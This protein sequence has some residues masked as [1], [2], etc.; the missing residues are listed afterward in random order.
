VRRGGAACHLL[1]GEPTAINAGTAAYFIG[2]LVIG[3]TELDPE[4]RL[5]I[6]DL[7]FETLRATH[8]GQAL[9]IDGLQDVMAQ[10]V[11]SGNGEALEQHILGT[12]RLKSAVPARAL[13]MIGAIVG[14]GTQEQIRALGDF[15]EALGLAFQIID[16]TLNLRGFKN[17]LKSRGEDLTEGKVTMPVAK[18]MSR[19]PLD[20]RRVF[21]QTL[22][23][24][25]ADPQV[26]AS[27]IDKLEACGALTACEQH[28]YN[29]IEAAW[30]A[31]DP[32]IED[33]HVKLML[34]A[35]SWYVLERHY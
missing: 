19:L 26:I 5:E 10:A 32:L 20:E 6:Y 29:L 23:S 21:Q 8:A 25:S 13:G 15:L 17:N 16:D 24:K 28:A 7:Y 31:L 3:S 35:F 14:H 30:K 1:Y 34:R 33:S 27:L 2:Q 4:E 22:R 12:H 11:E 18:A 9:D